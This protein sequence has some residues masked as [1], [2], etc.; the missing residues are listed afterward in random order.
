MLEFSIVIS[1]ALLIWLDQSLN[2]NDIVS[3][4]CASVMSLNDGQVAAANYVYSILGESNGV[5][6]FKLIVSAIVVQYA[7]VVIL[8]MQRTQKLGELIMMIVQMVYELKKFIITF[9]LLIGLFIIV[10]TQLQEE[11]KA[12]SSS[13]YQIMLDIFD[14]F[15]GKQRFDDYTFPEGQVFITLFVYIFNILLLSF[16]VAMFINRYKVVWKSLDGMRLMNIIKLKNSSSYDKLY[17]G[18]TTTFF[19]ISI[20]VLPFI[21]P[22][23]LFK[24]E[25]L[26]EFILKIQYGIMILMYCFLA[27]AVSVPIYPLMYVKCVINS[28]YIAVNNKRQEYKGQNILQLGLTIFFNPV[29][30][31]ASLLVDLASLPNLLLRDERNFEFKYQQSLENLSRQQV[32]VVTNLFTKLFYVNFKLNYGN[33]SMTLIDL[34]VMHRK[35]FAL[36]DN[37]HDLCCRGTKDYKEALA[38]VQDYNMTKILTRKCSVPDLSGDVK[39]SRCEFNVLHAV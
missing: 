36:L 34:M 14:G 22:L 38:N 6:S 28:I 10:G 16:L 30:I 25:R 20:I 9:G 31:G 2:Y 24:S 7:I 17:G 39:Q 5:L 37:L 8:M 35:I 11:V 33:R 23:I 3:K 29:I 27:V 15:N 19:P 13:F 12:Q 1:S 4:K 18:V 26:N 21:L 32:T